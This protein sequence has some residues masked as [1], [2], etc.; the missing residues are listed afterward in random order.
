MATPEQIEA[1]KKNALKAG[2]PVASTTLQTQY[3]KAQLQAYLADHLP[4][5]FD[6]QIDKARN[7]DTQAFVALMDRGY[8]KPAQAI[9]GADGEALFPTLKEKEVAD[10]VLY[11]FLGK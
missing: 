10:E 4:A 11:A 9:T 7:G 8:G 6:A 5:M 3:M 2:R 1:N